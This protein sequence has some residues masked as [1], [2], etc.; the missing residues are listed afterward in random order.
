MGQERLRTG[1]FPES[2]GF[3]VGRYFSRPLARA[4]K[5]F[6]VQPIADAE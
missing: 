4:P 1:T 2:L 6:S 3:S 5:H